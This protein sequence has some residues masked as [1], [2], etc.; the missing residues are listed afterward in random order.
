MQTFL[1]AS[2]SSYHG[3]PEKILSVHALAFHSFLTNNWSQSR[4]LA[5]FYARTAN[6]DLATVIA[7][8]APQVMYVWYA[9][10]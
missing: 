8:A 9:T 3:S 4:G 5:A 1:W 6:H 2:M 10:W 7:T